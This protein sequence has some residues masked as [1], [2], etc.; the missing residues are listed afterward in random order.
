MCDD[1]FVI[2]RTISKLFLDAENIYVK[3][4]C[5]ASPRFYFLKYSCIFYFKFG[6]ADKTGDVR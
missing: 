6:V 5:P 4:D 1:K 3:S 2:S